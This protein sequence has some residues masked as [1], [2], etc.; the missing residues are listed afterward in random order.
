MSGRSVLNDFK[1][2]GRDKIFALEGTA[3]DVKREGRFLGTTRI[4]WTLLIVWLR[5]LKKAGWIFTLG[6]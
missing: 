3:Q 1:D 6:H 4:E 5:S 2:I